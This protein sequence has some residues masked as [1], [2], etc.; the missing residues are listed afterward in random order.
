M[1]C[2]CGRDPSGV[3][4]QVCAEADREPAGVR[5][6]LPFQRETACHD[7]VAQM[8]VDEES[9]PVEPLDGASTGVELEMLGR[10]ALPTVDDA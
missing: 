4:G 7:C 2:E 3:G 8:T 1:T 5:N 9:P 10:V 6:N